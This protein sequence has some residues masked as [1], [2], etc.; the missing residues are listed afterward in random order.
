MRVDYECYSH[1][2]LQLR[3]VGNEFAAQAGDG[4]TN[5]NRALATNS[6]SNELRRDPNMGTSRWISGDEYEIVVTMVLTGSVMIWRKTGVWWPIAIFWVKVRGEPGTDRVD[7]FFLASVVSV[8]HCGCALPLW[9]STRGC[10]Q[11]RRV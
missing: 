7:N 5:A 4:V 2:F 10:I 8:Y 11:T 9:A 3:L 6:L 1:K